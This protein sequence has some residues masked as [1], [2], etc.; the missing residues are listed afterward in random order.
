MPVE[1]SGLHLPVILSFKV[2]H[3]NPGG[4]CR[5]IVPDHTDFTNC[6][7]PVVKVGFCVDHFLEAYNTVREETEILER[8]VAANKAWMRTVTEMPDGSTGPG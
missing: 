3:A 8:R 2:Y 6:G 4:G 1:M 5:R 7:K